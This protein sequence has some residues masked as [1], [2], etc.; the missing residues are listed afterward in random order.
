MN[1]R[2]ILMIE[3]DCNFARL[4]SM[5][6]T[7]NGYECAIAPDIYMAVN[8]ASNRKPDLIILDIGLPLVSGFVV[9]D[10][11]K[12]MSPLNQAPFI[13]L[14]GQDRNLT[15]DQALKAGASAYFAKPPDNADL[16]LAIR[17]TLGW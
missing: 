14:S 7:A 10:K 8:E 9:I 16:L 6:L 1:N 5:Q 3:D 17:T 4:L 11:L 13:V 15:R 12:A 2:R